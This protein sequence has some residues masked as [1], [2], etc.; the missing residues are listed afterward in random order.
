MPNGNGNAI[1]NLGIIV[2]IIITV[3]TL[4]TAV[5]W[6]NMQG[7]V[8]IAAKACVRTELV[9]IEAELEYMRKGG[10]RRE[11]AIKSMADTLTKIDKTVT[12]VETKIETLERRNP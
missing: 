2:G 7:R 12:R 11:D 6:W 9:P 3:G 4:A 8:E 5:A 1:R 10:E